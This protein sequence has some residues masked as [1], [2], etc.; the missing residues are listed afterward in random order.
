M[1]VDAKVRQ[2]APRMPSNCGYVLTARNEGL[3]GAASVI[4][5]SPVSF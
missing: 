1:Q 3:Y 2:K 5:V 4:W